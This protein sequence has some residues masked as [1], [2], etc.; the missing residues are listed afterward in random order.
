MADQD[1]LDLSKPIALMLVAV[2]HF[3]RD[4]EDPRAI[5]NTLIDAL[6]PGSW[7]SPRTPPSSE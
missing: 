5:V 1:L 4:D 2:L 7:S 6:E 3:I